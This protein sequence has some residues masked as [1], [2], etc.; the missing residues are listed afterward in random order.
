MF[1]KGEGSTAGV[2]PTTGIWCRP[3]SSAQLPSPWTP[4]TSRMVR[5]GLRMFP[6]GC[7]RQHHGHAPSYCSFHAFHDPARSQ[8]PDGP[9]EV[10]RFL[11][12]LC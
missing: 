4:V 6:G 3:L 7:S 10:Q 1:V 12:D 5:G 2:I 11:A 8:A 9:E